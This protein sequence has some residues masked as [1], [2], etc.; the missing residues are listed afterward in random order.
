[1]RKLFLAIIAITAII[2]CL[3][4]S[5]VNAQPKCVD[6][7]TD[8][9][10]TNGYRM[11]RKI[12]G[13]EEE[14]KKIKRVVEVF[15]HVRARITD[16]VTF[17]IQLDNELSSS[18]A[19][20][21]DVVSFTVLENVY[22]DA[23][24][25]TPL[26]RADGKSTYTVRRDK[27]CIVIPKQSKIY[28]VVDFARARYPFSIGGKPKVF[29]TVTEFKLENGDPIRIRFVLPPSRI[30]VNGKT[31]KTGFKDCK[32]FRGQTCVVG[33]RQKL[34]FPATV[35]SAGTGAGLLLLKDDSTTNAFA[36]LSFIDT[37]SKGSGI[38]DLITP[39]DALLK[40][41]MIFDVRTQG[42]RIKPLEAWISLIPEK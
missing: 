18:F 27:R 8:A 2:P 37:V 30:D 15:T 40:T 16:D 17:K 35:F 38:Q 28:G 32:V 9:E 7:F 39:P 29:V 19:K 3:T 25:P 26:L 6:V 31:V 10:K 11:E 20:H 33:R 22:G 14:D 1:M 42:L 12:V 13:G 21:S 36:A 23:E 34:Q 24:L 41:T 5:A 4:G